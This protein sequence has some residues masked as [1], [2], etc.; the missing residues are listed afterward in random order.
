MTTI[1]LPNQWKPRDYQMPAWKALEHGIKRALLIWHRRAGKDDVCLHWAATQTLQRVGNYWHMLPEY[2]QARK[3]VW[4]AVNPK[5]G[6]RRIDEAFPKAIRKRTRN[7]DMFIEFVN[8]STWQLV[9][10]DS[11]NSLVGSPPIGVT[12][13][14]WALSNPSAWAYLRPI[15]RENGGWA[16]F[17][18]TPRGNNHVRRMLDG[19]KNDENWF[20]QIL[21]V[22]HTNLLS[23]D[24]IEQEKREYIREYGQDD[25]LSLFAQEWECS[26]DVAIAGAYYARIIKQLEQDKQI[27]SVPYDPATP[28]H[29]AWDLG[30]ADNTVIYFWQI[31]GR[32]IHIIDR[33]ASTPGWHLSLSIQHR[34]NIC[35]TAWIPSATLVAGR[36]SGFILCASKA[37]T[38]LLPVCNS[39]ALASC[40]KK[41]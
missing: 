10:S 4:D 26:F 21:P 36:T 28:V 30:I 25:G 34:G 40:G 29:T 9:G 38:R 15:L 33:I 39:R 41:C 7:T 11:Y 13:S 2:A 22:Q 27:T 16:L 31:V 8:G 24:E 37:S 14:E 12:A 32:E 17:I 20:T 3:S 19:A 1:N 18:T 5:T 35:R 6:Q 23:F